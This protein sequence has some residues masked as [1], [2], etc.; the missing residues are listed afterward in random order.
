RKPTKSKAKR[1]AQEEQAPRQGRRDP[2]NEGAEGPQEAEVDEGTRH[3]D[4]QTAEEQAA[5]TAKS[6]PPPLGSSSLPRAKKQTKIL[7][8]SGMRSLDYRGDR[9]VRPSSTSIRPLSF[10]V[11]RT[12]A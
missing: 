8:C 6:A 1:G 11:F 5:A 9:D 10:A 7:S 12:C 2:K 4:A 3:Q